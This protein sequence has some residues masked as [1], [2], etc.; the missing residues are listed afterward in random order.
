MHPQG[1]AAGY[2][3]ARLQ[4]A[5]AGPCCECAASPGERAAARHHRSV[6]A[7]RRPADVSVSH[8]TRSGAGGTAVLRPPQHRGSPLSP[9]PAVTPASWGHRPGA[10]DTGH[11]VLLPGARPPRAIAK[12]KPRQSAGGTGFSG[13]GEALGDPRGCR[14]PASAADPCAGGPG[15]GGQ[16]EPQSPLAPLPS[17]PSPRCSALSSASSTSPGSP[18]DV[19]KVTTASSRVGTPGSPQTLPA[20]PSR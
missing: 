1:P 5:C 9:L 19:P 12:E 2:E 8:Q 3:C 15:A 17:P 14:T 11:R 16:R 7:G 4:H 13:A 20:S 18:C 6:R 10:G